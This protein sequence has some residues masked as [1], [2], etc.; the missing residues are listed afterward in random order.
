MIFEAFAAALAGGG[1]GGITGLVGT[2]I[3]KWDES[4]K[5]QADIDLQ[6]LQNEQ[7]KALLR[8]EQAHAIQLAS[9]TAASQERLADINA[10]ARADETASLDFRASQDSDRARY[11]A[12]DAQGQSRLVRWAMGLVDFARGMIR[13]GATVYSF[14]LLTMLLLWV[15]QLYSEKQLTL[16]SDQAQKLALEIIGT[17][18][19]L[20]TTCTTWWFGVRG[21]SRGK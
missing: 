16:T 2:L 8:M 10:Q 19:Y 21:T 20:A 1:L 15:M 9:L 13:P 12:P 5:R 6:R 3:T 18:T 4:K 7:T 11:L 14:V 17:T